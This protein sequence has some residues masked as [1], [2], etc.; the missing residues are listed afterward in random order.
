MRTN[1]TKVRSPW[2]NSARKRVI[3]FGAVVHVFRIRHM[4]FRQEQPVED[5][6]RYLQIMLTNNNLASLPMNVDLP[7]H[8]QSLFAKPCLLN[9]R[10][11]DKHD[12]SRNK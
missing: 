12:N 10:A 3:C 11:I 1:F 9:V 5:A 2:V 6:Q 4:F 8:I 7:T